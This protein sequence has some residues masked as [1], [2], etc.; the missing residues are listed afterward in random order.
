MRDTDIPPPS[1]MLFEPGTQIQCRAEAR[2]LVK[3]AD[4]R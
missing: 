2:L 4:N 3:L 1:K